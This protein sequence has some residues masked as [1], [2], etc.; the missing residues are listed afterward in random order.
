MPANIEIK[1]FV[2]D[3]ASVEKK[4]RA[5]TNESP[6]VSRQED[7][8]FHCPTGRL[9]LRISDVTTGKL[10]W[11]RRADETGPSRSE[12]IVSATNE[13]ETLRETL[14]RAL[15]EWMVVHKTR[16]VYLLGQTRVHLDQVEGLGTFVEL[17]VVL[18]EGQSDDD[19]VRIAEEL[20]ESL[21]IDRSR[22][23]ECAYADLLAC[24]TPT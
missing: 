24:E 1:A 22:L 3:L 6:H 20:M 19:G 11:Y 13:P 5:V 10:I 7:V 23:V 17:E 2:D 12:Y 18:Q 16:S 15:G 21:G 9:K 4:V 14:A 8:F